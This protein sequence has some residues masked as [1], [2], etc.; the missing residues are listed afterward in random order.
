[1]DHASKRLLLF[2][3][4]S[5]EWESVGEQWDN[6]LWFQVSQGEPT[7]RDHQDILNILVSSV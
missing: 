5:P 2:V 1:M 6:T 3:P 7:D 4:Q